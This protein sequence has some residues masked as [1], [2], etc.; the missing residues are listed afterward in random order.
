MYLSKFKPIAVLKGNL[1]LKSSRN[2]FRNGLVIFQFATSII[3]IIGTLVIN[4]QIK[5]IL[6][7]DL[8]FNKEQVLILRGTGT[9]DG[10]QRLL[11]TN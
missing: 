4:Q 5:Y 10:K 1:N 9:L 3:L 6:N 2:W 11:K 7:R 8:G